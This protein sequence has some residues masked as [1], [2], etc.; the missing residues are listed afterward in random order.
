VRW[1]IEFVGITYSEKT[2]GA[3][4]PN[5]RPTDVGIGDFDGGAAI[6]PTAPN[7]RILANV[8]KGCS[9]ASSHATNAYNH[10]SVDDHTVLPQAIG[11]IVDHLQQTIYNRAGK[12]IKDCVLSL[13]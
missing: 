6:C 2:K 10:P 3:I 13:S 1:L 8:W 7:A 12:S 4:K 9:Q 5:P 11:I